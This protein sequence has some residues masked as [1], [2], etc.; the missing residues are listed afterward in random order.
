ALARDQP[1]EKSGVVLLTAIL[2]RGT[3]QDVGGNAGIAERLVANAPPPLEVRAVGEDDHEIVVAVH[4]RQACR[5]AA[6]KEH[7]L[8]ARYT[9]QLSDDERQG[10]IDAV[11]K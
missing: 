7:E 10:R 2:R 3:N 4:P 6:E 5:A 8:G 11:G 9:R 1:V